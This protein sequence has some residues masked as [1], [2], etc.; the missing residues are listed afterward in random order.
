MAGDPIAL[1]YA[2]DYDGS[3]VYISGTGWTNP[4]YRNVKITK[5]TPVSP[6]FY[7]WFMA[8]TIKAP[9]LSSVLNDNSWADIATAADLGIGQNYWSVGDTKEVTLDGTVGYGDSY[10]TF[11]TQKY[12][13]YIIGFD[14]NKAKEGKGIAFQ[15]FKTAQSGGVDIAVTAT[16]YGSTGSGIIM[17]TTSSGGWVGSVAYKT[18]MPQW[19]NCFLS[20]LQAVIKSTMLYTDDVGGGSTAASNVKASA[21]EVYYLAEYELFGSNRYANTNEPAQQAQ[22]DYYKAGNSKVKYR[23]D[24]TTNTV[25]WWLRSPDRGGGAYFCSVSTD[26]SV[27]SSG[28]TISSGSAPCFKVGTP[29]KVSP[30]PQSGVT[31]TT[32]L[33][34]LSPDMIS[35]ISKCISNNVNITNETTTIYYDDSDNHHYM[36]SVGDQV[37]IA[38]NGTNYIFDVIGFNHDYLADFSAYGTTTRTN[39]AGITFQ[40]HDCF[41]TTY[42]MNSSNTNVGGWKE[43]LMRTSTMPLMKGYMPAEWQA[44]IK[45]C[46]T[47]SG[48]GGGSTGDQEIVYD[49][50]F[51]LSEIEIFGY[52]TYSVSGGLEGV[53]YAYYKAGN[54]KI[55]KRSGSSY[56]WWERSPNSGNSAYFC[57]VNFTGGATKG[58][59]AASLG[60]AFAFCV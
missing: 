34:N 2:V 31:Y 4:A 48:T 32:G 45:T 21:N 7:N 29:G 20:D 16:N 3:Q 52:T 1:N 9:K 19:K 57:D 28:A 18:I 55:K 30:T 12:W 11:D 44:I 42:K 49:D 15:G 10:A 53:Q 35:Y 40:M 51:L 47:A 6:A 33:N 46:R 41:A 36:I 25:I 39:M 54:S 5:D 23:S 59:A 60:V 58:Q 13:V 26:G 8:N 27:T 50:C 38:L 14:H 24:N 17:N 56:G 22:Y 43:S 37:T